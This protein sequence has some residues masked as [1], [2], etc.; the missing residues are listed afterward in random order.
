MLRVGMASPVVEPERQQLKTDGAYQRRAEVAHG[1]LPL[2]LH[3]LRE[4]RVVRV[5]VGVAGMHGLYHLPL[6]LKL[7]LLNQAGELFGQLA[8]DD[9]LAV[10]RPQLVGKVAAQAA[11]AG[12]P[13]GFLLFSVLNGHLALF[14]AAGNGGGDVIDFHHL[15]GVGGSGFGQ[16]DDG[17]AFV[18]AHDNSLSVK[19]VCILPW[20]SGQR[21]L[22][23]SA[24]GSANKPGGPPGKRPGRARCPRLCRCWGVTGVTR[25]T[26]L[27]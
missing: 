17:G 7:Q 4:G 19:D 6:M 16:A 8:A 9:A 13:A 12:T 11:K 24:H 1:G 2:A 3:V 20:P 10:L 15:R 18:L 26:L 5:N 21:L 23:P 22:S 25:V 27:F 14:F